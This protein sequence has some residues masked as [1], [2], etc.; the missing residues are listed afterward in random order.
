MTKQ[1]KSD[2]LGAARET[3]MG[4]TK[5]GVMAK[6]T[7]RVFDEMCLMPVEEMA[8]ERDPGDPAGPKASSGCSRASRNYVIAREKKNQ[9]RAR[10]W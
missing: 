4:L 1:Y 9:Q 3:A 5:A 7:M 8:P 2:A 6:R 10:S